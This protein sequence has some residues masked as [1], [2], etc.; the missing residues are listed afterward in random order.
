MLVGM[1]IAFISLF[2][3]ALP[4]GGSNGFGRHQWIG[5][6]LSGLVLLCGAAMR[7]PVLLVVGAV[8][9]GLSLGADY[10][11]AD[12]AEF[13][14]V[15]RAGLLLGVALLAAGGLRLS[16]QRRQPAGQLT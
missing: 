5:V 12:G 15:Q 14:A 3:D 1:V 13:G 7:A 6:A 4:L 10:L 16:R 11:R 8:I 2:A 9:G